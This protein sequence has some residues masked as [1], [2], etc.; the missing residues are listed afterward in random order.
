MRSLRTDLAMESFSGRQN[1]QGV[2]ID[3]LKEKD[4]TQTTVHID[5]PEAAEEF[6]KPCGVY[7]TIQSKNLPELGADIDKRL[8]SKIHG[9]L[10]TLLPASGDVLVIGLGNRHMTADA[11]GAKVVEMIVVTRHLKEAVSETIKKRLRGVCAAAPGVLGVTGI[12]TAEVVKGLIERVKPSAVIA[13]DALA[14]MA[15]E[16]ICTTVQIT[17]TG[18]SPGS[19]VG[20]HRL[21][22]NRET[23]GIP[24]IAIGVPMVVYAATIARDAI[25][26]ISKELLNDQGPAEVMLDTLFAQLDSGPMGEMVVTPREI[27]ALVAQIA[28]TLALG[29]NKALQ[30]MLSDEEITQ[31]MH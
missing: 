18:I 2:R 11:L 7:I 13:V 3:T 9:T 30:P 20:N 24:V 5:S 29:I 26:S 10:R 6:K 25:A 17:N 19:G 31:M 15:C 4:I 8:L 23:L 21:G 14:A 27:D 22:L 28:R 16:R 1:I 12:E